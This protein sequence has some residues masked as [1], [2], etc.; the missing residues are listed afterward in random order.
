MSSRT[1]CS[2]SMMGSRR[3]M[4]NSLMAAPRVLRAPAPPPLP[5]QLLM[6]GDD[7]VAT[8]L[9]RRQM[10]PRRPEDTKTN[11]S[12]LRAFASSW[13]PFVVLVLIATALSA[14]RS[15]IG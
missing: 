7:D 10:Q 5:V 14:A 8:W 6:G 13:L 12:L 2:S 3:F 11:K 4:L 15:P 9:G 1:R